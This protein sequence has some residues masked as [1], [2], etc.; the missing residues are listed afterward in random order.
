MKRAVSGYAALA[1]LVCQGAGAR[2]VPGDTWHALVRLEAGGLVLVT[3]GQQARYARVTPALVLDGGE[4]WGLHLGASMLLQPWGNQAG[5]WVRQEDWDSRSDWGQWV[6][7]LR[8][9]GEAAPVGLWVG[10]LEDYSLLSGHLVRR[11]SNRAH[12]DYHPAGGYVTSTLGP[13]YVEAFSSDVLGA[14]LV[15]A[16]AEV[17]LAHIFAGPQ[18]EP[19]RYTLGVSAVRDWGQARGQRPRVTLAHVDGTAVVGVRPGFEVH[20]LAGW[21]GRPDMAGAWGAVVGVGADVLTPTLDMKL[22]LEARRQRGGFRQGY[23]GPDHELERLRAQAAFPAGYSAYGEAVVGWDGERLGEVLQRHLHLSVGAEVFTWGGVD[24]DGRL[25][26]Q[27]SERR[28]EVGVRGGAR[29]LGQ[30]QARLWYWAE[31]RW[32]FARPLY[33]LAQGG[34]RLYPGEEGTLRPA[35]F[36][37]L[38]LGV[39]HGL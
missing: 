18:R 37:A 2:E 35:P 5:G 38:C 3:G 12:P 26:V 8:L 9:G 15:G 16:Q 29:G 33:A 13:V 10:A 25:A 22:R 14:R 34:T 7:A 31:V 32:R 27:L 17:D 23:F 4:D 39:D 21:G 28:L 1:L 36:V 20:V 11:Y 30:P 24:V 19:G 6:Q